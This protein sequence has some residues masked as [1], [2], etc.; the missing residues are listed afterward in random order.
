MTEVSAI[1]WTM[2]TKVEPGFR[3]LA[4]TAGRM[5][6]FP[7]RRMENFKLCKERESRRKRIEIGMKDTEIR[8]AGTRENNH[9]IDSLKGV[10]HKIFSFWL[11]KKLVSPVVLKYPVGAI[12]N[13]LKKFA[14]TLECKG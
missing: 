9:K 3:L 14:N 5:G 12:S 10:L 13:F 7:V 1:F 4:I 2:L 11:F 8:E 6:G